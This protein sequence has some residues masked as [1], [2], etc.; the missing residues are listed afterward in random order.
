MKSR[1]VLTYL[2]WAVIIVFFVCWF[3]R[4]A[5]KYSTYIL[6][7]L[8]ICESVLFVLNAVNARNSKK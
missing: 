1:N 6:S 8:L 3:F 4:H 2:F 7:A 5:I